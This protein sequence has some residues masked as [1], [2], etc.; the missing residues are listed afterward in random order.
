MS[1]WKG[2]YLCWMPLTESNTEAC[3][4]VLR[5][6]SRAGLFQRGHGSHD[7]VPVRDDVV[8]A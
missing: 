1:A 6:C 5:A 7:L 3:T 4:M 8:G 2:L